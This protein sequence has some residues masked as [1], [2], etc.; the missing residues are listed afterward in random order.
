M[1]RKRSIKRQ[2]KSYKTHHCPSKM[3]QIPLDIQLLQVSL[4]LP[5]V[6]LVTVLAVLL[7]A[8]LDCLPFSSIK[9]PQ[10][11]MIH[12]HDKRQREWDNR[13][14]HKRTHQEERIPGLV[15]NRQPGKERGDDETDLHVLADVV[16]FCP[17]GE[18]C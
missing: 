9:D 16:G 17:D 12:W 18:G 2:P 15:I 3:Q 1:A 8:R 14:H 13:A 5:V 6:T 10:K 11:R 4:P 7:A